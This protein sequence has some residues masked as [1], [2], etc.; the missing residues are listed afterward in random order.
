MPSIA[1][2][3]P[4]TSALSNV[5][6]AGQEPGYK[7]CSSPDHGWNAEARIAAPTNARSGAPTYTSTP[8]PADNDPLLGVLPPIPH[9]PTLKTPPACSAS[10][11]DFSAFFFVKLKM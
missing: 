9:M 8:S 4:Q 7:C 5:T 1:T 2:G 6:P 3:S 10:G 11:L